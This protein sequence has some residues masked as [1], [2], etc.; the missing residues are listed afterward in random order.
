MNS[1]TVYWVWLQ[2]AL[3][4]G[5]RIKELLEEFKTARALYEANIIEWRMSPSLVAKQI[6]NLEKT[7]LEDAQNIIDTCVSNG[8]EIIT[9]GDDNYPERL[10]EISNPPA[11]LYIDGILP[12]VD[13]EV[14]IGVVGTRKASAYAIK[15]ADIMCR[16]VA[17]CGAVIVSGGALGVDSAA[18]NGA[19]LAGGKTVAVLGC[20]LGTRYLMSNKNLRDAIKNNGALVTEF[21]PF[22]PA[23]KYT[24]PMRNR[25]ISGLSLGVLVVEAGVKSGSLITANY[26]LEQN[27]DVF[28]VPCS[29][30]SSDFSGTNKLID[31]GA[32][33]VTKPLDLLSPYA[34]EFNL[35][36]S[37]VKSTQQLMNE[38]VVQNINAA[39]NEDKLSF[40][41]LEDGRQKQIQNNEA[42]SRL[43]GNNKIVYEALTQEFTH[44]DIIKEKCNLTSPQVL[45]AL[46][47]LEIAE[48]AKSASGMRYKLS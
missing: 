29:I 9:Y 1:N 28:A 24:F 21:P 48:L 27:R 36:L 26:A 16:G 15:V 11:V 39:P 33:V 13:R 23:S 10:R 18:H 7:T 22:T 41:N 8:W 19:I 35:D 40:E 4:A 34:E 12:D 6:Q 5:S 2:K 14:F 20:G 32:F 25:I 3:G 31:D 43:S 45:T 37:R 17:D 47:A 38:T 30:L 46:T 44:I 42:V